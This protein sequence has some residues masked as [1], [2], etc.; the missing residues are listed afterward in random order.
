MGGLA[1]YS[2][3][4]QF[5]TRHLFLPSSGSCESFIRGFYFRNERYRR[6]ELEDDVKNF[7][8]GASDVLAFKGI[9]NVL[10]FQL[11]KGVLNGIDGGAFAGV[12][13]EKTAVPLYCGI[14][15]FE[16]FGEFGHRPFEDEIFMQPPC[17]LGSMAHHQ[18]VIELPVI[19]LVDSGRHEGVELDC[20]LGLR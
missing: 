15:D 18:L 20:P 10:I 1:S 5:S 2:Y 9:D 8:A 16:G 13:F 19:E 11:T 17:E 12:V 7:L 14:A 3:R 6:V 4:D